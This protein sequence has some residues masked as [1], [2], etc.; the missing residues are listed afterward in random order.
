MCALTALCCLGVHHT[1]AA[2]VEMGDLARAKVYLAAGDFRRAIEACRHEVETRPSAEA[3]LYLTYVY[4]ALD[5]YVESMADHDQWVR[6]EL[7]YLSLV[8]PKVEDFVDPPDVLT[9][10]AK[11]LMQSGARQ[12]ADI[13]A[14]MAAKI[15]PTAVS[16]VW[17]QQT[18]WRKA[19]PDGWWHG[20]PPEWNW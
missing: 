7:L 3:Y 10:I 15:D 1:L 19:K 16:V 18:A 14:A 13:A 2:Q 4:Q 8:T 5:A 17:P 9:R 20:I 12:Q 11:E 6:L